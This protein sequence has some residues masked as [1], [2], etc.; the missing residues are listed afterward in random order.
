MCFSVPTPPATETPSLTVPLSKFGVAPDQRTVFHLTRTRSRTRTLRKQPKEHGQEQR[1]KCHSSSAQECSEWARRSRKLGRRAGSKASSR[2][3]SSCSL[4][5]AR[6][7]L[8]ISQFRK[9]NW[10]YKPG[11]CRSLT[12]MSIGGISGVLDQS[13]LPSF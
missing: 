12:P 5:R 3:R 1:Q 7:V 11:H 8:R 9:N 4:H 13:S 2:R 6:T 10:R